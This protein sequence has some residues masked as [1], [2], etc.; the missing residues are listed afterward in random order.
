MDRS[1]DPSDLNEQCEQDL[2]HII[3]Q[4]L[5]VLFLTKVLFVNQSARTAEV[6]ILV[7]DQYVSQDIF[8][9]TQG[10]LYA[11]NTRDVP[12][13]KRFYSSPYF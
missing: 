8:G 2:W 1:A 9:V 5:Y 10:F 7:I 13:E 6:S 11:A 4:T 3:F 12:S